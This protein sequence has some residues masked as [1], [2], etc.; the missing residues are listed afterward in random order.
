M[1]TRSRPLLLLA[2]IVFLAAILR[3]SFLDLMEFKNDEVA[4]IVL[5][6][7]A[8]RDGL[9][10][11]GMAG[12][13]SGAGIRNPPGFVYLLLPVAAFTASPLPYAYWVAAF[14]VAAVLLLFLIGRELGAP[15]AGF[16]AAALL[17]A[18]PWHILYSR[19]IWAQ[20]LLPFFVLLLLLVVARCERVNKSRA[21]VWAGILA[22][23]I[24]QIHYSGYCVL[25]FLA[26]WLLVSAARRRLNCL[27]AGGG[28]VLGAAILVPYALYLQRTGGADLF[29]SFSGPWFGG[30]AAMENLGKILRGFAATAFSGGFGYPFTSALSPLSR[31][32]LGEGS[33][34]I[35]AAASVAPFLI[36]ALAA[37]GTFAFFRRKAAPVLAGFVPWLVLFVL[38]PPV[39]YFIRGIEAPPHYFLVSFPA[40][41]FLAGSGMET[42]SS[43]LAKRGLSAG[44]KGN[45]RF[46]G[47]ALVSGAAILGMLVVF[48]GVSVWKAFIVRVGT[49]EGTGGDYGLTY[50]VQER[51]VRALIEE[52]V[53]EVDASLLRDEGIGIR[54]LLDL[55]RDDCRPDPAVRARLI[56]TLLFPGR[57]CSTY[58]GETVGRRVGPISICLSGR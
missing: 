2:A 10:R 24:W 25:P 19:K 6:R 14:G 28:I 48:T 21:A 29:R 39:L 22:S 12:M 41:L 13:M 43:A 37:A 8:L 33:P 46:A 35:S 40:V 42:I 36:L 9:S 38:A 49:A 5:A 34:G 52:R 32:P 30:P 20:S 3:L 31:T 7:G 51:A 4:G 26:L 58:R 55:R 54:Y 50:R 23:L 57:K 44:G 56:D 17:A 1:M 16:W 15:A 45:G 11:E 53:A 27:F 18:H 47:V